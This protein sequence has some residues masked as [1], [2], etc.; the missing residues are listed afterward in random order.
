MCYGGKGSQTHKK[1][2]EILRLKS[3]KS[4]PH[5]S[6]F[7]LGFRSV[8]I[9]SLALLTPFK[10]NK[11]LEKSREKISISTLRSHWENL[12]EFSFIKKH[13]NEVSPPAGLSLKSLFRSFWCSPSLHG[14]SP[15]LDIVKFSSEF[16]YENS[17]AF[18][19]C[20]YSFRFNER[21]IYILDI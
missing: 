5:D 20:Q 4:S 14:T 2:K 19:F 18:F 11:I 12:Q 21:E 17:S 3:E 16:N 9:A 10:T 15:R 8:V 6:Q 1:K 7:S 13:N